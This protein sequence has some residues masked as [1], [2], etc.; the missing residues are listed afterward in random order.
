MSLISWRKWYCDA[1]EVM[2][3]LLE[4]ML[5]F[6]EVVNFQSIFKI[7]DG[8]LQ[9]FPQVRMLHILIFSY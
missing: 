9:S 7:E 3:F 8:V 6:K 2:E 1:S 4:K 5:V